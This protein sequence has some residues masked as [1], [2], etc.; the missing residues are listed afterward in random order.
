MIEELRE[1]RKLENEAKMATAGNLDDF[2]VE[3]EKLIVN[4]LNE[5]FED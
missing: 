5:F 4:T 3:K 2:L 1:L